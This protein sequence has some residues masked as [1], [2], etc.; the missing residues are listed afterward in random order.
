M[1]FKKSV[2]AFNKFS[3]IIE[4]LLPFIIGLF[5]EG[6]MWILKLTFGKIPR[7]IFI[8]AIINLSNAYLMVKLLK[9]L[10][11]FSLVRLKP[12]QF[13][14]LMCSKA[15]LLYAFQLV[16]GEKNHETRK[17][18]YLPLKRFKPLKYF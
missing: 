18:F 3:V 9:K 6:S 14:A 16:F 5:L 8:N 1:L 7:F 15:I 2:Y 11:I 17:K 13:F 12:F 10:D 4:G